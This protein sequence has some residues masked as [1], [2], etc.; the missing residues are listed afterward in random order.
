[1]KV[2]RL[3]CCDTFLFGNVKVII[4]FG[5]ILIRAEG[6]RQPG[7]GSV[8]SFKQQEEKQNLK[9]GKK[10]INRYTAF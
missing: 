9:L 5:T 4:D 8:S 10:K 6:E 2:S 3:P 7:K 1:M